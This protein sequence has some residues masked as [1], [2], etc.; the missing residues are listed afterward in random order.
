VR[1]ARRLVY[2]ER[3]GGLVSGLSFGFGCLLF[4]L[5]LLGAFFAVVLFVVGAGG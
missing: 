4:G 3:Q 5:A 1:H 2:V